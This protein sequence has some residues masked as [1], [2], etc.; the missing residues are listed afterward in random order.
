MVTGEFKSEMAFLCRKRRGRGVPAQRWHDVFVAWYVTRII[1]RTSCTYPYDLGD[2]NMI[3]V[4]S[5]L[6]TPAWI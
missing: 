4:T 6:Q 3:F 2:V 1:Q 5:F